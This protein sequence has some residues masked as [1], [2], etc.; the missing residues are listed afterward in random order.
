MRE[1]SVP[2][3]TSTFN[4]YLSLINPYCQF[5]LWGMRVRTSPYELRC[6]HIWVCSWLSPA[7]WLT[8]FG[9]EVA[10]L[11]FPPALLTL[12]I[13]LGAFPSCSS[14][15]FT[16]GPHSLE[17]LWSCPDGWGIAVKL[18]QSRDEAWTPMTGSLFFT[19]SCPAQHPSFATVYQCSACCMSFCACEHSS[20]NIHI[21]LF[22]APHLLNPC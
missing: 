17:S 7:A 18:F 11:P 8:C 5:P 13:Q 1:S 12:P 3:L 21:P 19:F 14:Q 20:S 6:V 4:T 16:F 10:R 22:I 9:S 15:A 2:G